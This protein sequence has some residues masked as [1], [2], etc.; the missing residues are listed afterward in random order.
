LT[1]AHNSRQSSDF[2]GIL[3]QTITD[4]SISFVS[5]SKVS[6]FAIEE[7]EI[8][9]LMHAVFRIC[10][11]EQIQDQLWKVELTLTSDDDSFTNDLQQELQGLTTYH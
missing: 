8:L 2:I 5:V 7:E 9:F 3:F 4:P 10:Q 1:F 11:I 6:V